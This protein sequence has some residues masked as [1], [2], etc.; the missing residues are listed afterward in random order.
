MSFLSLAFALFL[1]LGLLMFHLAPGRFR[2]HVLLALSYAFYVS[3]SA[4]HALLLLAVTV[5]VFLAARAVERSRT[6][7][8]KLG[9]TAVAVA[10]LGV[11]LV[12]F[13]CAAWLVETVQAQ[14]A[15]GGADATLLLVAPLGLSYYLFKLMGYLLDVYWEKVPVEHNFVSFALY[16]AFFP[17][18]VSGPIQ[19]AGDFLPQ[20]EA[21]GRPDPA[22]LT[23]GLRRILFGL[24]KKLVIADRLTVLVAGVHADPSAY[25]SLELLLGAYCFALQLYADFAGIT[26][27]ALGLGQLFGMKGP[28]NFQMPFFA[29]NVQDFWRRWHITLSS[30]LSDYLFA[31]L[32]ISLRR[33]GNIGLSMAIFINM[34]AIG[35]W[36]GAS[37]T[38]VA[39][40]AINGVF[41]VVSALTLKKRNTFFRTHPLLTRLREVAGP[42]LT[43]HLMVFA[44][45]FFRASSVP[46]ALE[47]VRHLIPGQPGKGVAPFRLDWEQ[48]GLGRSALLGV[49]VGVAMME[50]LTWA[51]RKSDWRDRFLA[52]P[53]ILRW[54]LYYAV[55]VIVVVLGN[56][57]TQR[58]IYA[59]F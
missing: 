4:T 22:D 9:V 56:L 19:R 35:V 33:L 51:G 41:M 8:T 55:I 27:I 43:F 53:R 50:A 12:G 21:L 31:P 36:H 46:L 14:S 47:Y 26:D 2:R 32:R 10:G 28:E 45:I 15:K 18:I 29:R 25:S 11:V 6:E 5:S 42:L 54:G 16:A 39:F 44:F 59:Q 24:F 3:A 23:A 20:L 58:F 13:K 52:A 38:Y 34:V 7:D 57:E 1:F 30:W 37:W 17:Q 40:G 48:L 49:L